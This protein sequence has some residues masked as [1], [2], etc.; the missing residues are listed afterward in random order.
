[1]SKIGHFQILAFRLFSLILLRR[2]LY[3]KKKLGG[4]ADGGITA[5]Y[6]Q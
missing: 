4:M 5:V 1:M 3:E 6:N 2:V